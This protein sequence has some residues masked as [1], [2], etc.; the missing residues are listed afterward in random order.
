MSAIV[1]N[2]ITISKFLMCW[3]L[4]IFNMVC[5]FNGTDYVYF[6]TSST[7]P[8]QIRRIEELCKVGVMH[9]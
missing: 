2:D 7:T 5:V 9:I 4:L 6:E 1:I 3:Y 8:Y